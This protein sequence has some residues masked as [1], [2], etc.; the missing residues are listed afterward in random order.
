MEF[1]DF[2]RLQKSGNFNK[3]NMKDLHRAISDGYEACRIIF[4]EFV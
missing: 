4:V 1:I 2:K 3:G